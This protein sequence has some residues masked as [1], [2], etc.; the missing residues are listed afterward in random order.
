MAVVGGGCSRWRSSS[1]CGAVIVWGSWKRQEGTVVRPGGPLPTSLP[2]SVPNVLSSAQ[3]T[4]HFPKTFVL[5][6]FPELPV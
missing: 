5:I 3:A 2:T 1:G 4:V 6:F